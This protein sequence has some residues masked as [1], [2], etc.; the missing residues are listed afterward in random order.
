MAL[1]FRRTLHVGL[2]GR[3]I[4]AIQHALKYHTNPQIR[5]GRPSGYYRLP[6]RDQVKEYQ[7]RHKL[8]A[9]GIIGPKTWAAMQPLMNRDG[10][11][12]YIWHNLP[13][14]PVVGTWQEKLRLFALFTYG[15]RDAIH[16]LQQR[17]MRDMQCPP[18]L[19]EY[20]DCSEGVTNAYRCAGLPDP[21][22][23]GYNGIGNTST[24]MAHGRRVGITDLKIG[25]LIFYSGP[26]HVA[27][28]LSRTQAW[29][30]GS[31][32]APYLIPPAYRSPYTIHRYHE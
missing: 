11:A 14:P 31:E 23:Y 24:L 9:D 4:F 13:P 25:D 26:W 8:H 18:S 32:A 27:M 20:M 3:D 6:T 30:Q 17:P 1:K 7:R 5:R 10:Y 21:N 12:Q 28:A 22:G 19:D 29:S 15:H 16:Y 2:H